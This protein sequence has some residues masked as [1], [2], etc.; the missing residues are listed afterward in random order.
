MSTNKEIAKVFRE[1]L[2][3]LWDGKDESASGV[4]RF[5]CHAIVNTSCHDGAKRAAK[6][7]MM[8]RLEGTATLEVWL[9]DNGVDWEMQSAQE[10]QKHRHEWLKML[11]EE[12]ENGN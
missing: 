3:L 10:L 11:I 4:H 1:A 9:T 8:E 5:I 7:V 6:A 2:K 12:F